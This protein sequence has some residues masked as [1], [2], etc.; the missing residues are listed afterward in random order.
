M[1]NEFSYFKSIFQEPSKVMSLEDMVA[2]IKTEESDHYSTIQKVR[3]ETDKQV[4]SNLKKTLPAVS[5]SAVIQ[6]SRKKENVLQHSG[7]LGIDID[8]LTNAA[9]VKE[10][11]MGDPYLLVAFIS[12]SGNG[13][14]LIFR[15]NPEHHL[16][17]FKSVANYLFGKYELTIDK[18]CSDVVRLMFLSYDSEIYYNPQAK[19]IEGFHAKSSSRHKDNTITDFIKVVDEIELRRLDIT[20]G[21]GSWLSIGF[22]CADLFG[23]SGREYFHRISQFYSNYSI[24]DTDK[25]FEHC[26]SHKGTGVTANTFFYLAKQHGIIIKLK[27]TS[28]SKPADTS[29]NED[30]KFWEVK[31]TKKGKQIIIVYTKL[32]SLLLSFGFRRY[33]RGLEKFFVRIQNNL[34]EEVSISQIQDELVSFIKSLPRQLEEDITSDALLEKIYKNPSHYFNEGRLSLLKH[35]GEFY[36]N[37]D[38]ENSAFV[39]YLNGFVEVKSDG[40]QL[41]DY[42]EL[43]NLVWRKQVLPR[44]FFPLE[45][46]AGKPESAGMYARFTYNLSGSE[47]FLDLCTAIG[48]MLHG[49]YEG[50]LRCLILTDSKISDNPEGRTGKTLSAQGLRHIRSYVEIDGKSFD[51]KQRFKFQEVNLDTQLVHLNDV[52][53][54]FNLEVIF[55]A[56]T[57]GINAEK[58]G[59]QPDYIKAK[60]IITSNRTVITDGDSRKDRCIEIEVTDHYS[61]NRSPQDDFGCWFFSGWNKEEW[62]KFDN[63]MLFCLQQYFLRGLCVPKPINLSHRKLIEQTNSDFVEFMDAGIESGAIP[64]NREILKREIHALF[65]KEYP[66]YVN[67]SSLSKMRW[68]TKYLKAY[69]KYSPLVDEINPVRDERKSG[70][71]YFI[72]LRKQ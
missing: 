31:E 60:I 55:G 66:D 23:E 59:L 48:Y 58:K 43:K 39:Y 15:C 20:S 37:S 62:L 72:T 49:Y 67:D 10:R 12:P 6:G 17:T 30:D 24:Q 34:I 7:L 42:S 3:V 70:A 50:K 63:F 8:N 68:F 19:S 45:V 32:N 65:L 25:Q 26:L 4:I 28:L 46:N 27:T 14:K 9:S 64:V 71:D 53:T 29:I 18:T 16:S 21:Y 1:K 54:N 41:K 36:F 44:N 69:T 56:I 38:L 33:D 5:V 61:A 2:L 47:R 22:V 40:W 57:E 13:L 35:D 51:S 11:V 52:T